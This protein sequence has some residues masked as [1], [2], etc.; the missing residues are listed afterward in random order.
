MLAFVFLYRIGEG[1]LLVEAPLFM[2]SSV[3]AGGLGLTL[4]QKSMVDGTV[5]TLVS[6]VGGLLG[7]AF[8]SQ[9]RA[10]AHAPRAAPCA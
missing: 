5:S 1:F 10:E 6:I 8:V 2:Q 9:V 7:G 4:A 3:K